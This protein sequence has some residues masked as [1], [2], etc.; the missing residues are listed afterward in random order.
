MFIRKYVQKKRKTQLINLI[1]NDDYPK[2]KKM[3]SNHEVD[4]QKYE[5]DKDDLA[6]I[7]SLG[8]KF[9]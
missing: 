5:A 7:F 4:F 8:T 6:T 9:F 3:I 1:D 2:I